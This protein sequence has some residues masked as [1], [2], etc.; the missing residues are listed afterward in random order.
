LQLATVHGAVLDKSQRSPN[1]SKHSHLSPLSAIALEAEQSGLSGGFEQASRLI[2]DVEQALSRCLSSD[3]ALLEPSSNTDTSGSYAHASQYSS[4]QLTEVEFER[5]NNQVQSLIQQVRV[6]V[7]NMEVSCELFIVTP[8][9]I[10]L[11][12]TSNEGNYS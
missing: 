4:D 9:L 2:S 7:S 6:L 5:Q 8:L 1:E 10:S 12:R 3:S 11:F